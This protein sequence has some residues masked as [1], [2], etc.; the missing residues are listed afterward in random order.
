MATGVVGRGVV[1]VHDGGG[2]HAGGGGGGCGDEVVDHHHLALSTRDDDDD[3]D[4][5]EDGSRG[6]AGAA[7]AHAKSNRTKTHDKI[8]IVLRQAAAGECAS[9]C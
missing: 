9:G 6:R 7:G 2:L 5:E 4:G 8:H 1:D 3:D